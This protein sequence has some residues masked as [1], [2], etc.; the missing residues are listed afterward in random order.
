[1]LDLL[2]VFGILL[3]LLLGLV[4]MIVSFFYAMGEWHKDRIKYR[5]NINELI[6]E[7]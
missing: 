1:M 5:E 6:N 2:I 3:V 7:D 4:F